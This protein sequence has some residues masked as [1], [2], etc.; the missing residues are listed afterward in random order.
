MILLTN[1]F[2]SV[3]TILE[4]A[5]THC[6]RCNGMRKQLE[7]Y[8]NNRAGERRVFLRQPKLRA[9][10]HIDSEETAGAQLT[11]KKL[12]RLL[13]WKDSR[14]M[15]ILSLADGICLSST[16]KEIYNSGPRQSVRSS[17]GKPSELLL[18][19]LGSFHKPMA[20]SLSGW[21]YVRAEY[22][23]IAVG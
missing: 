8:N 23:A 1:F 14:A 2:I 9:E 11:M 15:A 4:F 3:S 10:L 17:G 20:L 5:L 22:A 6:V 12:T 21:I 16:F 18:D 13:R 7:G 19:R